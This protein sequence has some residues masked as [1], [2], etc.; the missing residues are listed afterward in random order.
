MKFL[1][2]RCKTRYS[3][4][5]ER[6]RG[7]ILKIRC[8]NCSNVIT[9][10]EGMPEPEPEAPAVAESRR[11]HQP[12]DYM[13]AIMGAA[14][15]LK[16]PGSSPLQSAFAQAME[17]PAPPPSQLEEEWYVSIDGDQSGPFNLLQAQDWIKARR[18]DDELYCWCEGFDDWLPV[19]KVSHFRGIR[20]KEKKPRPAPPAPPRAP[21]KEEE[22]K[23]L[24]A[25]ALAALE[26]EVSAPAPA[27]APGGGR[28]RRPTAG[29]AA[30]AELRVGEERSKPVSTVPPVAATPPVKHQLPPPNRSKSPSQ[31]PLLAKA[32]PLTGT[33]KPPAGLF[34]ESEHAPAEPARPASTSRSVPISLEQLAEHQQKKPGNGAS[35]RSPDGSRGAAAPAVADHDDD[36]DGDAPDL[37]D[38]NDFEIGEVSRV[39]RLTDVVAGAR[40]PSGKKAAA[41]AP[42]ATAAVQAVKEAA[43]PASPL[44][45]AALEQLH[46]EH[47]SGEGAPGEAPVLAPVAAPRKRRSHVPLFA[48]GGLLAVI[49]IGM[50][51]LFAT[52]GDDDGGGAAGGGGGDVE[53]LA[54]SADDPRYPRGTKA[55]SATPDNPVTGGGRKTGGG[56][57][58]TGGG[59]SNLGTGP[60]TGGTG[61][62]T[63][64]TE[65][66]IG[67]DGVPLEPLTPDDVITQ[68]LKMSTG[69][70]RCYQRALKD[71]PFLKVT[72]I[73]ALLTIS[74]DGKVTDVSLDQMQSQPLG[75]CL[76]AAI[77]RWPFRKSTA[78]LNTKITLKFEQTIN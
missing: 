66:V 71:D 59:G 1:C 41:P 65:V 31:S 12:T 76:V 25:A 23:P 30:I 3:I 9:V 50:I 35:S 36:D 11:K 22:P 75:Q 8:K 2:D 4:A 27:A 20:V 38:D 52:G 43:A 55:G 46:D 70:Q 42:R 60:G 45:E 32:T 62:G 17:K 21:V 72:S 24:F 49:V 34:D 57:R 77:K 51:V 5:D 6:V 74:R 10:R 53:N 13:P 19:E 18:P 40:R 78:G 69:T 54:L 29:E 15:A 44:A 61:P 26:A 33:K 68:A 73:A 39:V 48:A 58:K 63:G 67:P 37:A 28:A 14:P 56:G 7:K 16:S 47:H 64:K